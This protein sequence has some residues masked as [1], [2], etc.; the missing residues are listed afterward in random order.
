[1][2]G[3]G[4]PVFFR[5]CL[6]EYFQLIKHGANKKLYEAKLIIV[7]QGG[8]GKTCLVRKLLDNDYSLTEMEHTTQGINIKEW[9]HKQTS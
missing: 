7:G 9:K 6:R 5:D 1:M 8:V 4:T 2:T 3:D